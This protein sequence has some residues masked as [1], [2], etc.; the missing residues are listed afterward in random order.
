MANRPRNIR[1]AAL[2]SHELHKKQQRLL[3]RVMFTMYPGMFLHILEALTAIID[4]FWPR[5]NA[6]AI[7][8]QTVLALLLDHLRRQNA[9]LV[10]R[11]PSHTCQIWGQTEY[12]IHAPLLF[13]WT[14]H[15]VEQTT[16]FHT[17][18]RMRRQAKQLQRTR[19]IAH[20]MSITFPRKKQK[21]LKA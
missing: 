9:P 13:N 16:L 17:S 14:S 2:D 1:F 3:P 7:K 19:R 21:V 11:K 8:T 15:T 20:L 10:L 5:S 18:H 12:I 6:A 4:P